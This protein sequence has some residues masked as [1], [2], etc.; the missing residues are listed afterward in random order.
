MDHHALT[1][2]LLIRTENAVGN[3]CHAAVDTGIT[4]QVSDITDAVLRGLPMDYPQPADVS[5]LRAMI[6]DMAQ[7]IMSG[8][9]YDGDSEEFRV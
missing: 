7:A 6:D 2:D 1:R 8:D 5:L 3:V 9:A 4:F